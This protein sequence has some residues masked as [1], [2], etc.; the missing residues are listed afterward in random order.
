MPVPTLKTFAATCILSAA[1]VVPPIASAADKPVTLTT[2]SL[3]FKTMVCS[4]TNVGTTPV[5]VTIDMISPQSGTTLLPNGAYSNPTLQPGWG[6]SAFVIL[7][8]G[9]T[10]GYCKFTVTGTAANVRA[11]ACAKEVD[12][13]P[14]LGVSEAR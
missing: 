10:P 13:G 2:S 14:C 12:N 11:A 5:S 7:A 4:V 3:D 9:Y 1:V 8:I 6:D